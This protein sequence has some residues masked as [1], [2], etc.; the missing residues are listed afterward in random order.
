MFSPY[1]Q[2]KIHALDISN[3]HNASLIGFEK[4]LI[5]VC[6]ECEGEIEKPVPRIPLGITFGLRSDEK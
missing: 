1:F 3:T 4:K 6:Y 2:P 5:R